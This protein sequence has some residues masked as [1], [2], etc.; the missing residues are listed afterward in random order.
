MRLNVHHKQHKQQEEEET[1]PI[2]K[3]VHPKQDTAADATGSS[4]SAATTQ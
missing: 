1:V 4:L 3:E 2:P